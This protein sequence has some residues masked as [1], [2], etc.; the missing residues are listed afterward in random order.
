[1]ILL[2]SE[3]R[4]VVMKLPK[5]RTSSYDTVRKGVGQLYMD[6]NN[7]QWT[8]LKQGID[9]SGNHAVYNTLQQIYSQHKSQVSLSHVMVRI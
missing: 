8:F 3:C 1:M 4:F 7:Q 5:L 6:V 9:E 2:F